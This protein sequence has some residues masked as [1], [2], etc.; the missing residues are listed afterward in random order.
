MTSTTAEHSTRD[1]APTPA[2]VRRGRRTALLLFALG[3]GP[4]ILATVMFYTG[5]LNPDGYSN[6]GQ[7]VGTTVCGRTGRPQLVADGHR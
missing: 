2:Q 4:M 5:W 7:A 1:D 6:Q 3:F